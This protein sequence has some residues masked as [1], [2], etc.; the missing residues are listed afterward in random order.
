MLFRQKCGPRTTPSWLVVASIRLKLERE[1]RITDIDRALVI[2][3]DAR[4]RESPKSETTVKIHRHQVMEKMRADCLAELP[5][6]TDKLRVRTCS[7][8]PCTLKPSK[9]TI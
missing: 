3:A 8:N 7:A 4:I 2:D 9:R 6:M 5:T 1:G